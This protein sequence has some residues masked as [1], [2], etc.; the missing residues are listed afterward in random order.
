MSK[1]DSNEKQ[2]YPDENLDERGEDAS[3][4]DHLDLVSISGSDVRDGPGSLLDN[5]HPVV[6]QQ[7]GEDRECS[8]GQNGVS[9]IVRSS[10]NVAQCPE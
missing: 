10:D 1:I 2:T 3:V 5:V 4:D 7:S 8:S 6:L 9:L